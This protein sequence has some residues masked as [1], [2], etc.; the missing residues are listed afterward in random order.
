LVIDRFSLLSHI[1]HLSSIELGKLDGM[2]EFRFR[3]F[4]LESIFEFER[5]WVG[6]S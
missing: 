1:Q 5:L 6:Q 3:E 4:E 2:I